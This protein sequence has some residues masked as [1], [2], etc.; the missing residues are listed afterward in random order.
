MFI[1]LLA[2]GNAKKDSDKEGDADT[3]RTTSNEKETV[4]YSNPVLRGD[5]ADP[6]VVRVGEDYYATATSSEWAPLY[7][8][9][10]S[11]NLVDRK[12]IGHVFHL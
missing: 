1:V 9:L 10:H 8:I 12:I 4:S 7:P 5:F 11:T 3:T 2:C 6:S